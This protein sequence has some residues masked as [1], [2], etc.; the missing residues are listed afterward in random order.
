MFKLIIAL[1]LF[2]ISSYSQKLIINDT[3]KKNNDTVQVGN[4]IKL[5]FISNEKLKIGQYLKW[6]GD[7]NNYFFTTKVYKITDDAIIVKYKKDSLTIPISQITSIRKINKLNRFILL[8]ITN[9]T[10]GVSSQFALPAAPFFSIQTLG[11]FF[12]GDLLVRGI[13]P[14]VFPIR[15]LEKNRYSISYSD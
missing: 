9:A 2:T 1:I 13:E 4:K 11:F 6:D 3:L 5:R 8:F 15:K 12:V 10:L 14:L 7:P